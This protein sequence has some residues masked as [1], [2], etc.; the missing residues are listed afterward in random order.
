MQ[1]GPNLHVLEVSSNSADC[2]EAERLARDL[3]G[4]VAQALGGDPTHLSIPDLVCV[5]SLRTEGTRMCGN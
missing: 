3:A 5:P 4:R 2:A 1:D